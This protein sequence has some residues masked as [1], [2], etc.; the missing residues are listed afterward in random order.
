MK[1]RFPAGVKIASLP[2]DVM[3][4]DTGLAVDTKGHVWGWGDNQGGELCL[5]N[6]TST[7]RLPGCR[8][9]T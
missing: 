5:G 3:P 1:V 9:R 7:S 6:Q 8:S 4:F 2:I